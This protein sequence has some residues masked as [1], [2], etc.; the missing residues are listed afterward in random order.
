MKCRELNSEL[1]VHQRR[2]VSPNTRAPGERRS[3]AASSRRESRDPSPRGG[4]VAPRPSSAPSSRHAPR[5]DPTA[6]QREKERRTRERLSRLAA[7][8]EKQISNS[9][10]RHMP[11]GTRSRPT[12][13]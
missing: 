7:E 3:S 1:E 2:R 5:F 9:R 11:S 10:D 12:S 4:F 8:K 6:Y 13:A